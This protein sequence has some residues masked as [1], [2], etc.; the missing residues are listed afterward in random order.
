MRKAARDLPKTGVS[1]VVYISEFIMLCK[2]GSLTWLL[3]WLCVA[4]FAALVFVKMGLP[5]TVIGSA[6]QSLSERTP[7]SVVVR[8][9]RSLKKRSRTRS[10]G[11]GA[12]VMACAPERFS[13]LGQDAR[14]KHFFIQ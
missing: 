10:L 8:M 7:S 5:K 4:A 3:P 9:S 12:E 2:Q 13:T 1:G 14:K 6:D 11:E